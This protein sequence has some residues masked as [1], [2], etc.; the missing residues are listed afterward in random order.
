MVS[1]PLI[2]FLDDAEGDIGKQWR[3]H[4]ALGRAFVRRQQ[5]AIRQNAGLQEAPDQSRHLE[6]ADA[7]AH[8]QHQLVVIDMIEAAL[9]I[10]LDDPLVGRPLASAIS[11]LRPRPHSH[12]DVLQGAVA[13]PPGSEPVRDMPEGRLEDRLQKVLDRALDDA[14]AH[15]RNAQG[16]EL[17][18][19]ARL[20]DQLPA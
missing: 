17:P 15:G 12:A 18:W 1:P 6:I 3:D 8:A 19:L 2:S 9:D 7:S 13:A 11:G 16:T 14:V 20:W 5:E 10:A 4:P